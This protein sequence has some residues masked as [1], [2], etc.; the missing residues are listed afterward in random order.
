M[1]KNV[2]TYNVVQQEHENAVN[3]IRR[4]IEDSSMPF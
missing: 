1:Y 3:M 4:K 2:T